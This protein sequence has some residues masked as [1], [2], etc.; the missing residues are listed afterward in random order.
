M[1]V[2]FSGQ[3]G[4]GR[5]RWWLI[6]GITNFPHPIENLV[7]LKIFYASAFDT[8][9]ILFSGLSVCESFCESVRPE[10]PVNT[11]SQKPMNGI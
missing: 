9:G 4:G 7:G 10:N 8:G 3:S 11:I 1:D 2:S 6:V 5:G